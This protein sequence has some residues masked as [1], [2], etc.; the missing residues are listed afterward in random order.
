[1]NVSMQISF[2]DLA[3]TSFGYIPRSWIAG[4]YGSL[5]F[6]FVMN[7]IVSIIIAPFYISTNNTQGFQL[8]HITTNT[9]FHFFSFWIV[10]ILMDIKWYPMVILISISLIGDAEHLFMCF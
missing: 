2:Q 8:F 4:S 5:N 7:H 6:D 10:A 3:F 1:M 9:C